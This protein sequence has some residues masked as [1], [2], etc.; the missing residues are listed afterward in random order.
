MRILIHCQILKS[1]IKIN[2]PPRCTL[3]AEVREDTGA[4][5][6]SHRVVW[7]PYIPDDEDEAPD[8]DVARLL[9]TTHDNIGMKCF[10]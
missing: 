5:G 10:T 7:C 2:P 3:L 8:D 4:V 6:T 1:I 9:L